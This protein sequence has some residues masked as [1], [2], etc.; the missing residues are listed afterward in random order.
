[1]ETKLEH[2]WMREKQ[3][4]DMQMQQLVH[5]QQM[6]ILHQKEKM[7]VSG[8]DEVSVKFKGPKIPAYED[9]KD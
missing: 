6:E 1:M 8:T 2:K 4:R 5:Q 3:D 7:K 9:G